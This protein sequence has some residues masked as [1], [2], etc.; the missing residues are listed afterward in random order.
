M[1]PSDPAA[2][3]PT[4]RHLPAQR[5]TTDDPAAPGVAESVCVAVE[6]PI[7][8]DVAGVDTYVVLCSPA[9]TRELALGFLLTEGVID[10][11]SDV[12]EA[13]P[14]DDDPNV[15]RVK[16]TGPIPRVNDEGRNLLIVSAC[17]LCGS[18]SLTHKLASLPTVGRVL[19]LDKAVLR[20]ARHALRE[21]QP[22]FSACGGSQAAGIFDERGRLLASAEDTGR[23][24]ALDKAI[25]KCLLQG[26]DMAGRAAVLS[27][28]A[29]LEMVSKCSRAGL[30]LISAISAPSSLAVEVADRCQITLCGFVRENRAT[31][32]T[33]PER[34]LDQ[35]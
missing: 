19:Q 15:I 13:R 33:H 1:K 16:L 4:V 8:I 6:A 18:E 10:G 21:Q 9:D 35:I 5:L 3:Q 31:V 29:S 28:R 17:G 20:V 2:Q 14:C 23:H 30:E 12:A 24:N 34:L 26:I 22:L 7:T 27:G 11:M 32:F 25:G